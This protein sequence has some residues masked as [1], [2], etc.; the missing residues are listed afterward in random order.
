[1][2]NSRRVAQLC[3]VSFCGFLGACGGDDGGPA[4]TSGIANRAPAISGKPSAAVTSN[5]HYS[6]L[7]AAFDP[8]GDILTFR[9]NRRPAWATFSNT[10]GQLQ[11]TPTAADVGR[12]PGVVISVT[13]GAMETALEPFEITVAE[14]GKGS[15]TLT[16]LP[17]TENTDGSM[18]TDLAGYNIYW[19]TAPGVYPNSLKVDD[20]RTSRY[21]V[22]NLAP[23]TYY[24][25]ATAFNADGVESLSSDVAT[26]RVM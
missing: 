2:G 17:P 18:L 8:D 6:F 5:S 7:P 1:M 24:F 20:P 14:G 22:H 21:V 11:G 25:I 23:A 9:I 12:Y 13:D 19:G 3:A 4:A 15:A 26:G 16:L 10:T